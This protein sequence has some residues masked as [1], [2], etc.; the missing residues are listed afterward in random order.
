MNEICCDSSVWHDYFIACDMTHFLPHRK[1]RLDRSHCW[2]RTA[3]LFFTTTSTCRDFLF[4]S[5]LSCFK[6]NSIFPD[7]YILVNLYLDLPW[8]ALRGVRSCPHRQ[9]LLLASHSDTASLFALVIARELCNYEPHISAKE[10]CMSAKEA[11]KLQKSPT[12]LLAHCKPLAV[13]SLVSL[14]VFRLRLGWG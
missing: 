7:Y 13:V 11:L 2:H 4:I 12:Y 9:W 8:L 1:C 10:P 5:Q 3:S 6:N 14:R